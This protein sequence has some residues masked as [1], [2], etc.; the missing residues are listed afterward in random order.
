MYQDKLRIIEMGYIY[1]ENVQKIK[2]FIY[3]L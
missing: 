2:V 3:L 1:M